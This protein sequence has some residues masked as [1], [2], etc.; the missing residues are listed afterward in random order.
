M[1]RAAKVAKDAIRKIKTT[2]NPLA[3]IFEEPEQNVEFAAWH[4]V[5]YI[6]CDASINDYNKLVEKFYVF[7]KK[8]DI[9]YKRKFF[10]EGKFIHINNSKGRELFGKIV[11]DL[12]NGNAIK[13]RRNIR[14]KKEFII[15]YDYINH[16]EI[17]N[18]DVKETDNNII[19]DSTI[20]KIKENR[21]TIEWFNFKN[22]YNNHIVRFNKEYSCNTVQS[23]TGEAQD[24][25]GGQDPVADV[26]QSGGYNKYLKNKKKSKRK[27][28]KVT[29]GGMRPGYYYQPMA[30]AG[31]PM[32]AGT[33]IVTGTPMA[34]GYNHPTVTG[35]RIVTETPMTMPSHMPIV[36]SPMQYQIPLMT[37]SGQ[38]SQ[39][40]NQSEKYEK[41]GIDKHTEVILIIKNDIRT[42]PKI[43]FY[44]P[45]DIT[46]VN[47]LTY[48]LKGISN[49]EKKESKKKLEEKLEKLSPAE[50]GYL[51]QFGGSFDTAFLRSV[52]SYA[53][54]PLLSVETVN[55]NNGLMNLKKENYTLRS[56]EDIVVTNTRNKGDSSS[57][58]PGNNHPTSE[59]KELFDYIKNHVKNA[60][61]NGNNPELLSDQLDL[62][63]KKNIN[64]FN[65]DNKYC[66][67]FEVG[68]KLYHYS[69]SNT[70]VFLTRTSYEYMQS[71]KNSEFEDFKKFENDI[72][73]KIEESKQR[74]ERILQLATENVNSN[75]NR[76][77]AIEEKDN[78]R[79]DRI[80][81]KLAT[82]LAYAIREL[83]IYLFKLM[84]LLFYIIKE[85][86]KTLSHYIAIVVSGATKRWS[87][88][89]AGFIIAVLF[90]GFILGIYFGVIKK[91]QYPPPNVRDIDE[92]DNANKKTLYS[93]ILA[94]PSDISNAYNSFIKFADTVNTMLFDAKKSFDDI[95]TEIGYTEDSELLEKRNEL[96][97]EFDAADPVNVENIKKRVDY[98]MHFTTIDGKEVNHKYN[99]KSSV[100]LKLGSNLE[101]GTVHINVPP[102]SNKYEVTCIPSQDGIEYIGNDCKRVPIDT[103]T[104]SDQISVPQESEQQTQP[105]KIEFENDYDN[106]IVS[107]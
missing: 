12:K 62:T 52:V 20:N 68:N 90:I 18:K 78:E 23:A 19:D 7:N 34:A 107:T 51:A 33:R 106:I 39:Q 43:E 60:Q 81:M 11:D 103:K 45:V 46:K 99:P 74:E 76:F 48:I 8:K 16:E 14:Q 80:L 13:R 44:R 10:E 94:I 67:N 35:T 102:K 59:Q 22:R 86:W 9:E 1:E 41:G 17:N 42:K 77:D 30:A 50:R 2:I 3:N 36:Y 96:P 25:A 56:S 15:N 58:D 54:I 66:Y 100:D 49:K 70:R 38:N 55:V 57:D 98:I 97:K 91:K 89:T 37:M 28:N 105:E 6:R 79:V 31:L 53:P 95:T 71:I 26:V 83:A 84:M 101:I 85:L 73:N 75:A 61:F 69:S 104:C 5:G 64:Y 21:E 29:K 93:I 65:D 63:T 82:F 40:Q 47:R 4:R 88:V 72:N 24:A 87:D 92:S 32:A 27:K